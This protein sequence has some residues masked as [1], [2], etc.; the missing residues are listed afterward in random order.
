MKL[1]PDTKFYKE[2]NQ[3]RRES[4]SKEFSGFFSIIISVSLKQP[5]PHKQL[6]NYE[7]EKSHS[8][9]PADPSSSY[10]ETICD[11]ETIDFYYLKSLKLT[12]ILQLDCT[13]INWRFSHLLKL[14]KASCIKIPNYKILSELSTL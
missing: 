6:W 14:Q 5:I 7:L 4:V 13:E 2:E 10:S 11:W 9:L 8:S 12:E 3:F 1:M